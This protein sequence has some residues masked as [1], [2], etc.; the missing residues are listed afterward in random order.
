MFKYFTASLLLHPDKNGEKILVEEVDFFN[1]LEEERVELER[2][3]HS[4]FSPD[5]LLKT[6]KEL[7]TDYDARVHTEIYYHL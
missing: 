5:F 6:F 3:S 1:W 2:C 4:P 7:F